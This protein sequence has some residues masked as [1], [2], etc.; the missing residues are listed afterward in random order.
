ALAILA[1]PLFSIIYKGK[2]DASAPV[3]QVLILS[4]F[5]LPMAIIAMNVLIGMGKV[6]SLFL[7]TLGSTIIFFT[8]NYLLVPPLAGTGAALAVLASSTAL[9]VFNFLAR[10]SKLNF[11][12]RVFLGGPSPARECIGKGWRERP[13][14]MV[15]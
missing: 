12:A 2:Y 10:R 11:W 5:T 3:F 1:N 13:R 14:V 4:G 9:A 6:K 15:N 8:L 7:A